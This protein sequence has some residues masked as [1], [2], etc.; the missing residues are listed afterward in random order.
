MIAIGSVGSFKEGIAYL[1]SLIPKGRMTYADFGLDRMRALLNELDNPQEAYPIVHVG[2]TAGKGS[3]ATIAANIFQTAGYKTGLHLS[4]HLEDIRERAQVNGRLMKPGGFVRLV[5]SLKTAAETVELDYSYGKPTYFELLV[6]M[7]FQHF[8]DEDV[9]IALVEVGL[10]GRLDGTNIV[11]SLV[12]I[13]TNVGLDHTEILGD[14]IEKIAEDKVGIF[15]RNTDVISGVT[16]PSV[17]RIVE[18]R[19]KEMDCNLDLLGRDIK[20]KIKG[21]I[22]DSRFDFRTGDA[23][24]TDLKLRLLGEHQVRNAALA[25]DASLKMR[26]HGFE[27]TEDHVRKALGNVIVPGRFELMRGEPVTILDGAHN[28]MKMNALA[29][30]LKQNY[31]NQK[32]R[33]VFAAKKDKNISGMLDILSGLA[34]KFYFTKF[35]VTTDFGKMMSFNPE[36]MQGLTTV[37]SEVIPDSLDAYNKARSECGKDEIICVTGSLYLVG[38]LRSKL[39]DRRRP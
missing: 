21:K 4:P 17:V 31:A 5:S 28:P 35:L 8:K 29:E 12:S 7:A 11:N 22:L 30:T 38:E 37:S 10:G 27:I 23:N 14:T 20:Y 32:I 6:A 19:A 24:Y 25:L 26:K 16:Q 9:D 39:N 36:E 15:K 18:K 13:L 1:E 33:V 34:S 3:T 2:G